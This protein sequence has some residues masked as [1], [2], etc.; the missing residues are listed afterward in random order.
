[1]VRSSP[2][3]AGSSLVAADRVNHA[4]RRTIIAIDDR[5]QSLEHLAS[6]RRHA[7]QIKLGRVHRITFSGGPLFAGLQRLNMIEL[8]VD[9]FVGGLHHLGEDQGQALLTAD[10]A[11]VY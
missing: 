5:L 11:V 9:L 10:I 7:L 3:E 1:M 2:G 6:A 4:L 8:S